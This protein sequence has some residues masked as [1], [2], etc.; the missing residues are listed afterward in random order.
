MKIYNTLSKT[1]ETFTPNEEGIV[2]MYTCGPTVYHYAHIGNLRTYI[3]EDILEKG[4]EYLGYDVI[5][6]MNITDVGHLTS[7]GDTGDDKMELASKRDH[8][9]VYEIAEF[10]T[11]AFF[12]DCSKLNIRKPD[13]I[14]PATAN[15]E[16]NQ[17]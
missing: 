5:R 11:N 15:I 16:E 13:I 2:R 1:V 10:Y 6:V 14:S 12:L 4:L 7:D 8:K 9:T 17:R 3:F